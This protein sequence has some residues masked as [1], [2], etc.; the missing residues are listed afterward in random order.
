[1][2]KIGKGKDEFACINETKKKGNMLVFAL[3]V[4]AICISGALC[5]RK[6]QMEEKYISQST[7]LQ[8]IDGAFYA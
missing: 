1:M 3:A 4:L 7:D 5:A 8:N 2:R 6:L